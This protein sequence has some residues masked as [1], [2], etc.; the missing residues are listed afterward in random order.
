MVFFWAGEISPKTQNKKI[1]TLENE[2]NWWFSIGRSDR[3]QKK[4]EKK[5]I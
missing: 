2:V 3:P 4:K 5:I 1:Q